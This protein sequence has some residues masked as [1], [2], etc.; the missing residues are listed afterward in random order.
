MGGLL[1]TAASARWRTITPVFATGVRS[2][3]CD[4][5]YRTPSGFRKGRDQAIA[6]K[7]RSIYYG[8]TDL[9]RLS[10]TECLA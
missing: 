3:K 4:G 2:G 1:D 5:Y 9:A 10:Q 6:V 8:G 7:L